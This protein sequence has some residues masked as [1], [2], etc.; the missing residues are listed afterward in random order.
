MHGGFA[1][2]CAGTLAQGLPQP[3]LEGNRLFAVK[4]IEVLA[5]GVSLE[6]GKRLG[7]PVN[8]GGVA[9]FGFGQKAEVIALHLFVGRVVFCHGLA[10]PLEVTI[11][12]RG[13]LPT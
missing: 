6:P 9:P 5:F 8:R 2:P 11:Q 7:H 10:L 1:Q 4:P 13:G 12:G 3:P